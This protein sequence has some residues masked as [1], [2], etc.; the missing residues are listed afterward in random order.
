MKNKS[1]IIELHNKLINGEIKVIDIIK[2]SF[3]LEKEF[4]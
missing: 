3:E 1:Q 4:E 2:K